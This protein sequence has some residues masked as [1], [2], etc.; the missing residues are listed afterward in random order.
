MEDL[1]LLGHIRLA[2]RQGV[3]DLRY[4]EFSALEFLEDGKAGGFRE[5]A[6]LV[7]N[8]FELRGIEFHAGENT[9]KIS[10]CKNNHVVI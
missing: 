9:P 7:G 10:T 8:A 4:A 2:G 5:G 1:E 6:K 3:H